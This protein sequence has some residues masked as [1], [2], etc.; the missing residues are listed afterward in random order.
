MAAQYPSCNLDK[1]AGF[2]QWS[3]ISSHIRD[4][5]ALWCLTLEHHCSSEEVSTLPKHKF[6]CLATGTSEQC[7]CAHVSLVIHPPPVPKPGQPEEV[8]LTAQLEKKASDSWRE[9]W[10]H[11]WEASAVSF[12]NIRA[13]IAPH[14]HT[15]CLPQQNWLPLTRLW[16]CPCL[17][18][19]WLSNMVWGLPSLLTLY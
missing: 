8:L 14:M 5:E 9:A 1:T 15:S 11:L 13:K 16:F 10:A 3:L 4:M 17:G 12:I 19:N 7:C 2:G 18:T 6:C